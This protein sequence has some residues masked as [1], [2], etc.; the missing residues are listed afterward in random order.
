VSVPAWFS[1][2]AAERV[3]LPRA[4]L[5]G[6]RIQAASA[7]GQEA[8]LVR[9]PPVRVFVAFLWVPGLFF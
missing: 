9:R 8:A 5:A 3:R 7:R 6:R 1:R 2:P 4:S